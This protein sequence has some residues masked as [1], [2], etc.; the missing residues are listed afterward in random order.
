MISRSQ[1]CFS[2]NLHLLFS[3]GTDASRNVTNVPSAMDKVSYSSA[4]A[5]AGQVI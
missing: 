2:H 5:A 1:E 3:G 4:C